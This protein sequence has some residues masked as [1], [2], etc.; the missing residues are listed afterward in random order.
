MQTEVKWLGKWGGQLSD[1][2][3]WVLNSFPL[4][5][6]IQ[7]CLLGPVHP[8]DQLED[9]QVRE[10]SLRMD[11]CTNW[12]IQHIMLEFKAK[13]ASAHVKEMCQLLSVPGVG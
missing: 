3:T 9:A 2:G 7:A 11:T 12:Y 10:L 13:R 5:Q 6:P 8:T 1:P 4:H